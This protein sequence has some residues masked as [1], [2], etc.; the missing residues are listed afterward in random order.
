MDEIKIGTYQSHT[1]YDIIENKDNGYAIIKLHEPF[2]ESMDI[3]P[4]RHMNG[5]TTFLT[6]IYCTI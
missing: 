5:E 6:K 3:F 1:E 4:D 2:Y